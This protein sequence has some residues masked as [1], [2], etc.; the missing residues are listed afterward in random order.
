MSGIRFS[1]DR[2]HGPRIY[3]R[4]AVSFACGNQEIGR[5]LSELVSGIDESLFDLSVPLCMQHGDLSQDN[6][7]YGK[8][9]GITRY[10]WIDWEHD[11]NRVFFY[12]VF[13]YMLN[14]AFC[15]NDRRSMELY[16][17]DLG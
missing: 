11:D 6:L 4:D 1:Q 2:T 12:D 17:I 14:A 5:A 10:W 13:F 3:L 8:S 9:E 16:L 15:S 7:I